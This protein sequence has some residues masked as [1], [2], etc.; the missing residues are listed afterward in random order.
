MLRRNESFL[1]I[2]CGKQITPAS[3]TCR[4]HCPYCFTSLHVDGDIPGDRNTSCN[5]IML[6]F[7]QTIKH[8]E[9]RIHFICL[10]CGKKHRNKLADDD[11]L[12]DLLEKI[13][14]YKIQTFMK[15]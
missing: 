6:P 13:E 8:G 2:Q 14:H 4:N 15:L 9:T 5:G 11:Q 1:C 3:K 10:K 7:E 12:S